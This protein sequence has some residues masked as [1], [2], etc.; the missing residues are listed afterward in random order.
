MDKN[1]FKVFE[2]YTFSKYSNE[3]NFYENASVKKTKNIHKESRLSEYKSLTLQ[4]KIERYE[5]SCYSKYWA[6]KKG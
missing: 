1:E 4:I 6:N 3:N 2:N 5:A